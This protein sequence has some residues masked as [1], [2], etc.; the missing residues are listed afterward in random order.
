MFSECYNLD[1]LN[2][3]NFNTLKC[4]SFNDTF[5]ICK[6]LEAI[7]NPNYYENIYFYIPDNVQVINITNAN[8]F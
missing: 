7:L 1:H 4:N 3:Q 5:Y 2:L 6:K 8:P